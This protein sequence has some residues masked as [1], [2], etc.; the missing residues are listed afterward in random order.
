MAQVPKQG[1]LWEWEWGC[2][3]ERRQGMGAVGSQ[4]CGGGRGSWD[5]A[6]RSCPPLGRAP[7]EF[8]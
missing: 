3:R 2:T 4:R 6:C 7:A 1:A 5:F 8:Q